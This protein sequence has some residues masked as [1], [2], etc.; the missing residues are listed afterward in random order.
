Q[1]PT[2]TSVFYRYEPAFLSD[3]PEWFYVPIQPADAIVEAIRV[4]QRERIPVAYVDAEF[5]NV[6]RHSVP[7][8]DPLMISTIGL[9]EYA[10]RCDEIID[11]MPPDP[12]DQLRE[13]HMA[14][15]LAELARGVDGDV[16]FV[17][18]LAHWRRIRETLQNNEA[19]TLEGTP[20]PSEWVRVRTLE[21]R[22]IPHLVGDLPYLVGRYEKHR[23]GFEL[24]DF[25]PVTP[26]KEL[27]LTTRRVH[28]RD[29]PGTL[30]RA[31]PQRLRTM[32]D[33]V[34]KLTVS[35]GRLIP[36]AFDLV[37]AAK[38]VIGNDYALHLLAVAN[39]YPFNAPTVDE[40]DDVA[41]WTDLVEQV[42]DASGGVDLFGEAE[43]GANGA[44]ESAS[45][46][47]GSAEAWTPDPRESD[48]PVQ[49][50][51]DSGLLDGE[52]VKLNCRLPGTPFHIGRLRLER[53]PDFNRRQKLRERW[54]ESVQC[55]WPPEDIVIENFRD[56]VGKR[57]LSL[58]RIG[59][60]RS[61]PFTTSFLD[62]IDIRATMRDVVERRIHVRE[63][64]R[65]PGDVGAL[66][67]IFEEDDFGEAFPWRTTWMAEHPNESTLAFYATDYHDQLIG[68][69][70]ARAHYGGC[71]LIFPPIGIPDIWNDM[72][73]ERARTP[74]ERLLLA[75]LYWSRDRYVVQV[76]ARPPRPEVKEEATR[77]GRHLLH[78]PLS[79]F[80]ATTLE[81]IRR[82]HVLNGQQVRTWAHRFIR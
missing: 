66:V 55:S 64:P 13:M 52:E 36:D 69:G 16:L 72:R 46:E 15:K 4:A 10:Q 37:T 42:Y 82:V 58:A 67:I 30:E 5:D 65:V 20:I 41:S 75:A 25:E 22:S 76:S 43:D 8:P 19:R 62:G 73:F 38:G 81:R 18:G 79:T 9:E 63:E 35:R 45:S 39:L 21:P 31:E 78:L 61:E 70:I 71:L 57:A 53:R 6:N 56:Y 47:S 50:V 33:Y 74:S 80:G 17:C 27:L 49:M 1:L 3:T 26:L 60:T 54:D 48:A 12:G 44:S 14:F 40:V 23:S 24:D 68:P 2:I 7:L 59:L 28:E 34:R 77:R 11:V 51:A 32:L 29:D